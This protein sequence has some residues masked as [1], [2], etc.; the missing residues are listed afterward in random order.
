MKEI[1]VLMAAGLGS[2][3][4]PLT[5]RIAKPL[6][7]VRGTPLIETVLAALTKRGVSEIYVVVGY[8]KEQFEYLTK[9]YS[10]LHLIE[11]KVYLTKNNVSSIAAAAD[12]MG[13]A[14]CFVCEADLFVPDSS[15]LCRPIE[16]S[17]YFGKMVKGESDDWVFDFNG[18]KIT[19]VHKYG[20][21]CYNM[22][23][24]SFFKQ[25]DAAKIAAA[26]KIAA[27]NE[28]DYQLFWDDIVNRM[29]DELDLTIH[30]VQPGEI[31]ECDTVED[32]EKL[33]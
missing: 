33:Q 3:M 14:D 19:G 13:T 18:E 25:D 9:K 6:V 21:D 31:V 32:L 28:A 10:K 22:V 30:E 29:T 2:R 4:R 5:D 8:K 23:G 24:V 26:C 27:E 1:A 11:N 17:G 15:L 16:K 7:E 12:V 20:T